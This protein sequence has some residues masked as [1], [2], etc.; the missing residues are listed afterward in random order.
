MKARVDKGQ[1]VADYIPFVGA[2]FDMSDGMVNHD[3]A[4]FAAGL[5]VFVLDIAGG[6]LLKEAGEAAVKSVVKAGSRAFFSG[7]GTEAKAIE[8]GFQTLGQTRAGKNLQKLT[9]GMEYY[10]PMNGQPAS[11]AWQW[12]SRLSAT[13]AKGVQEGSTV[14]VFLNNPSPS[15]IWL[16][17]E[18][19]ILQQRGVN[20][21]IH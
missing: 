12:W 5:G 8:A 20:I 21:I 19:P 17:V 6:E 4:T 15:S 2:A 10:G 13:Y 14:N 18:K 9:K 1:E 3:D 16:N 7:A 11:Q